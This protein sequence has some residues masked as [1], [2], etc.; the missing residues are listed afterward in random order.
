MTPLKTGSTLSHYRILGQLGQGGQATAYKAEDTRLERTVVVKTLLPELAQSE[1]ARRRFER[2]ARLASALDHPNI[3][4]IYDIGHADGWY[5]IVMPFIPGRTLK[6]VIGGEPLEPMSAL[7]IATQ[8]A[9]AL[10]AAHARGIIHRDIKP[11]NIIVNDEGKV[12]VLDFGL[13]KMLSPDENEASAKPDA[14]LSMTE[15]GVPYGT[16]GYGSPEQAS[17]ER[18]DH[19]TDVFSLGVVLYEMVTGRQPFGGRNRIEVLHSTMNQEPDPIGDF[20][21]QAPERLQDILDRA[22]AKKPRDRYGSMV[23]LRDDLKNLLR[24]MAAEVGVDSGSAL[25]APRRPRTTWRLT[26]ALGKVFGK[27]RNAPAPTRPQGAEPRS[28]PAASPPSNPSSSGSSFSPSRP[29][30]WGSE[31]RQTIAVLPFQN[32]SGNAEDKF[33]GFSLADGIITE[34]AH[35]RQLVVRPSQY[36]AQFAGQN[37]DPRQ[38][39]EALAVGNVLTGSFLKTPERF[40]VTAQL[41]A[42]KTGEILW[43]DKIDIA[44]RDLF[45]IQD[46]IAERV[47]AGLRLQLTE[48]EQEKIEKPLTTNPESYEYYLRGRD[49]LFQYMSHS[50]DDG[51]LDTAITMFLEAVRLDPNFARAHYAL[52]RCYVHHAQGYGGQHYYDLAAKALDRALKLDSNISGARL[53]MVYVYLARG[54]KELALKTL[55]DVRRLAP[56]DPSVFIV[57]GMIYRLNGLYDKALKQYDRLLELNPRDIV[58]ASYNR[59]RIYTYRHEYNKA[60]AEFERA[61]EVE[62]GH[63]LIKTFLALT[64]FN[65]DR[66][67]EAQTL[68]EEVLRDHPHFDALEVLLAWCYSRQERHDEA[69]ALINDSVKDVA[70]ADHDFAI[71]LASFYAMENMRDEAIS[72]IKQAIKLGNENYPLFAD[73]NRLDNLRCDLRF[74][75]LMNDLKK[76]WEERRR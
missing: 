55:A 63:P 26:G 54:E 41:I 22:L 1:N 38:V 6:E 68:I 20:N 29:P 73:N 37:F 23:E 76:R 71:W 36:I 19:R 40:R 74:V 53:Q 4:A 46:L 69:R 31:T 27:L 14:E 75:D 64:Y 56:N 28:T 34:L 24:G 66:I 35:L 70:A 21:P 52:G 33:Y 32:L 48:A 17:G 47:I 13:A 7:S 72:W 45:K 42:S 25:I 60:I 44:E 57:A 43:S 50:F 5:Y 10:T 62:P 11:N 49:L 30:S 39:A 12:K 8:V 9:E 58:I 3:C 18:V 16:L 65:Q 59:G 67:E 61:R 15:I 2:E 51:D